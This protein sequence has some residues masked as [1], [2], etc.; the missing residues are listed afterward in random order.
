MITYVS[1]VS[2]SRD[3]FPEGRCAILDSAKERARH[4]LVKSMRACIADDRLP[5]S[6]KKFFV[7]RCDGLLAVLGIESDEKPVETDYGTKFVA[8]HNNSMVTSWLR[9]RGAY[10]PVLSEFILRHV[11]EGDFCVDAGANIGYFSL[12][13]AQC[14]GSSGKVMAIEAAPDTARRLRANIELNGATGIVE[15][16]EAACAQQKGEVTLYLHPRLDGWSRLRRPAK[17]D[18]DR[19]DM[20]KT[21]LPQNVPSDTLPSIV[22]ADAQHVSFIKMDIEG[23]E[24]SVTP[25]IPDAFSHPRLVVALEARAPIEVTLRPFQE[26]GFRVYDLH[27]DYRWLFE[28]KV[29]SIT[30]V[31]YRDFYNRASADVLVSREPLALA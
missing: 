30:E 23:A 12:L 17:G 7:S 26:R 3:D 15:V 25:Q 14:I 9:F 31:S 24:V 1:I 20:G 16:I 19:R 22:G 4:A 27:N 10:E 13:F 5:W 28:R 21:W 8:G 6:A 18:R 11:Q 2:G 29:P